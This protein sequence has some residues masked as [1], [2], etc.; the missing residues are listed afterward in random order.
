MCHEE[1]KTAVYIRPDDAAI[2]GEPPRENVRAPILPS[3]VHAAERDPTPAFTIVIGANG[4]GRTT[5]TTKHRHLVPKR[6]LNSDAIADGLGA[7]GI[8]P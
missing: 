2:V 3:S 7:A 5:W 6:F 4:A 1:T 8:P